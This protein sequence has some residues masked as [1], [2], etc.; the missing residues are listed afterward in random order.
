LV[1]VPGLGLA[2]R[3][4][5]G[6]VNGTERG[7]WMV[8]GTAIVK[9]NPRVEFRSLGEDE[10]GV[11]L[12][13]NT[14]PYHGLNEVGC[15]I[16]KLLDD[17]PTFPGLLTDLRARLEQLPPTFDAE[18]S[19]FLDKLAQRISFLRR[20]AASRARR[21]RHIPF[22]AVTHHSPTTPEATA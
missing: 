16:W 15:L 3:T 22:G 18:I 5:E 11:L 8:D 10:G 12:H 13:L 20:V 6:K 9:L 14:S 21:R 7:I 17:E 4:A 1:V 19:E 2:P